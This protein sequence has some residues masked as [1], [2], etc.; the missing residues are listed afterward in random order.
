MVEI[1]KIKIINLLI[2]YLAS[3]KGNFTNLY[4]NF[5]S[6]C[7]EIKQGDVILV[8]GHSKISHIIRTMTHSPWTHACL[9]IGRLYDIESPIVRKKITQHYNCAPDKQLIIESI[10][11]KGTIIRSI[12]VYKTHHMRI[13]RPLGISR[14]HIQQLIDFSTNRIGVKYD[15][16]NI[17]HIAKLLMPWKIIRKLFGNSMLKKNK[18][19]PTH[20]ICSTMIAES[21]NNINYP[22]S[23]DKRN[24]KILTPSDFDYS[25]YF[26]IIKYPPHNENST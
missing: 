20:E 25:P 6:L 11:G 18:G 10:L 3:N 26:Q 1:L 21:F 22:I 23:I 9:Y 15:I 19:I 16:K 17:L 2:Q 7:Y 14:K 24:N 4:S 8:E 13:C 5:D 12:D